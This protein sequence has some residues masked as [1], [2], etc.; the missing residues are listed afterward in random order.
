[1]MSKRFFTLLIFILNRI[2]YRG[3]LK[4]AIFAP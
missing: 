4:N 3:V 2:I 1:M